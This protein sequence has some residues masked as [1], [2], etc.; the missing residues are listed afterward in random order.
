MK[1]YTVTDIIRDYL[2]ANGYDG[3]YQDGECACKFDSLFPWDCE[4]HNCKPGYLLRD[5]YS[6]DDE[7]PCDHVF[8]IGPDKNE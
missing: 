2:K 3:L 4:N 7:E 5:D 8:H 1:D 6:C